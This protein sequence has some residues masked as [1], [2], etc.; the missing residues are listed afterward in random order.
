MV[1]PDLD[2][3]ICSTGFCVLRSMGEIDPTYLFALVRSPGFVNALTDLTSGALYPA[4]S[5]RDV[6]AQSIPLPPLPEQKRIAAELDAQMALVER[7][8]AATEAELRAISLLPAALLREV[9]GDETN[10]G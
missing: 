5:D 7:A 6:L 9:F 3:Q 8:R 1:S 10:H 4:V 2:S